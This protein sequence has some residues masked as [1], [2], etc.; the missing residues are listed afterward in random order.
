MTMPNLT[1]GQS[2]LL[3]ALSE[4]ER[5]GNELRDELASHGVQQ[6]SPAFYQMMSRLE[7]SGFVY[8]LYETEVIDGQ[9]I[10]RR[11][12]RIRPKGTRALEQAIEYYS[13][14]GQRAGLALV[15]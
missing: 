15:R 8:G 1:H 3:S 9:T 11:R 14:I 6:S 5:W 7:S 13:V 10:K 2:L 4:G 12:Y